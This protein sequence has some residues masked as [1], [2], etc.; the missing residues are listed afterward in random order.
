MKGSLLMSQYVEGPTKSFASGAALSA[1]RRVIRSAGVL[2]YASNTEVEFGTLKDA[3]FADSNFASGY[4][5][6]TVRLRTA[7][8]TVKMV[9]SEAITVDNPVYAATNGRIAASG[10]VLLGIALETA[11]TDG[12]VIEVLRR[13][14]TSDSAAAG[15]TTAAAFEV[16][17]DATTPKIALSGQSGGTGDFTTTLKPETTLS[18]DNAIIVPEADGDTL[19]AAALAQTL[20]SKTL[21]TPLFTEKTEVVAAT[22][23]IAASESGSVF[24]LNHATEF[25]S[26]LPAPAAGLTF[27]FIVSGAPASASYTIVTNSS[28]NII[29]GHLVTSEDAAGSGDS[30]TSGCDTITFVDGQAV[31]GDMVEVHCDGTNWF[32]YA[33]SK[34][35]AGITFTTA[36]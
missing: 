30:E 34:V 9:A 1:H 2:A 11:T 26:T 10:T 25:V 29:K 16:D 8:G 15:G 18:G 3:T 20:S 5:N 13:G 21:T 27:K 28:A 4:T 32:A 22:N 36:S 23:V 7:E 35:V 6:G 14:E 33:R 31:A 19:V 24:F 17:S 12:D